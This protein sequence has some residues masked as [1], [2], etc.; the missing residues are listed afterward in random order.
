LD[1]V[2]SGKHTIPIHK[3]Y[4]MEEIVQAHEDMEAGVA[5][6]K[7]VVVVDEE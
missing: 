7:L 2:E 5:T 6:G 3:V 4:K 1:D